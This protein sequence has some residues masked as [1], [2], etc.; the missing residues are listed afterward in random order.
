M[1]YMIIEKFH[2]DKVQEL[3]QRFQEKGRL[4]PEGLAYI[5]SW[6]NE[7]VTCCYQVMETNDVDKLHEWINNWKDLSDFEIIPVITSAQAKAKIFS[8]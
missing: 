3:Y 2:S 4:M 1:L 8:S 5:N 7:D 6:I